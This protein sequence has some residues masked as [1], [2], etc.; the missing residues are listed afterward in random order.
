MNS[1][2]VA[3][4][5]GN[6]GVGEAWPKVQQDAY[7]TLVAALCAAY[8]IPTADCRGHFEWTD[9]KVDPAGNSAWASG[10]ASWNMDAFRG[11]LDGAGTGG[12]L[13]RSRPRRTPC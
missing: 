9:R 6:N 4:E 2:A 13:H 11:A 8:G 12:G 1:Y 3:I 7:I 10:G 5:A